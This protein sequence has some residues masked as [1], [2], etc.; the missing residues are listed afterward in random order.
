MK[1]TAKPVILITAGDPF[2]IGPEVTVRAL[3]DPRVQQAC[4]PVVLGDT[5]TL[6]QAGFTPQL[7]DLLP[8]DLP[9][10]PRLKKPGPTRWGGEVSFKAVQTASRLAQAGRAA[11]VVTA[12]ISKQS[13]SMADIPYTGHTEF[14]RAHCGQT[15]LMMFISGPIRCALVSEH[16]AIKDLHRI[17]T[18]TRIEHASVDFAHA[19]KQLGIRTPHIALA[20]LNPH[21]GDNGKFGNEEAQTILPAVRASNKKHVKAE[22]PYPV[23]A[24][25]LAH[26]KGNFD[27]ILC[28]YHDQALLG[29]KLAAKEPVV[30]V[31]AGLD[32]LRT[33]PTHGTAFDIAGNNKA[34][35]SSMVSAILFAAEHAKQPKK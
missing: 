4:R 23:D 28:M 1:Q 12:P 31:T 19:L 26:A 21:G 24:L 16:F 33:S 35:A 6:C 10:Q 20:S 34:D 22:G 8:I 27:G 29:L 17:L 15:A 7:A 13:W 11:A 9:G 18:Q 32:F 5:A 3:Q 14:F 25:W 30:H 2:G